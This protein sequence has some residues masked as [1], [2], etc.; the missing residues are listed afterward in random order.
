M[1]S[2]GQSRLH[3]AYSLPSGDVAGTGVASTAVEPGYLVL[4]D[5][6]LDSGDEYARLWVP[7]PLDGVLYAREL[8]DDVV[9][10]EVYLDVGSPQPDPGAWVKD[11]N[12]R[13]WH[14]DACGVWRINGKLSALEWTDL[15]TGHGP[16]TEINEPEGVA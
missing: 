14:L 1:R 13:A 6:R 3:F 9:D 4:D 8:D 15:L 11:R 10:A 5:V 12:G 16:L 2:A 7:L